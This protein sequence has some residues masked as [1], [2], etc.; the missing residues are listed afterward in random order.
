MARMRGDDW[1]DQKRIA[2]PNLLAAL[3][4]EYQRRGSQLVA[5]CPFHE[6]RDPS[7]AIR[8]AFGDDK[9]GKHRCLSCHEG[10]GIIKLVSAVLRL[11]PENSAN[12][13]LQSGLVDGSV[14]SG[15]DIAMT[16][17]LGEPARQI[18]MPPGVHFG[19]LGSW[20][21]TPRRYA[22]S[23]GLT[24]EQVLRWNIGYA[25]DG[26]LGGRLVI[27]VRTENGELVS[28]EAR[29]FIGA[30]NKYKRPSSSEG[31]PSW[32]IF[33]A[34]HW[35]AEREVIVT[36]GALNALACERAGAPA[37]AAICGSILESDHVLELA[38]R[39]DRIVIAT[40]PDKAGEKAT[41]D[42]IGSFGRWKDVRIAKLPSGKDCADLPLAELV[43]IL[44]EA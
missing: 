30:P 37:V 32:A 4:I 5:S 11:D 7:W 31:G 33:G 21:L 3:G 13:L 36:E 10:G 1:L 6:D 40:D 20:T 22:L 42:L 2:V 43:A 14:A 27:P 41:R 44:K 15:L 25:V 39:F 19:E 12:W 29:S 28:Y 9:N 34:E 17:P 26:W 18:R 35:G 8:D 23:R 16:D 38:P 24:P